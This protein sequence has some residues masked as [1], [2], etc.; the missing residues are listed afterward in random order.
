MRIAL[1]LGGGPISPV[2]AGALAAAGT[3]GHELRLFG[4]EAAIRTELAALGRSENEVIAVYDAPGVLDPAADFARACRESTDVSILNAAHCVVSGEADALVSVC[5][6]RA[7]A[8]AALWHI[9]RLPGVLKPV[10]ACLLPSAGLRTLFL[11]CGA[12]SDCKPWHLLQSALIGSLYAR[13]VLERREPTV[14]ILA[15]DGTSSPPDQIPAGAAEIV[16]EAAGL[17]KYAGIRF[18]GTIEAASIARGIADVVVT[19]GDT[20]SMVWGSLRGLADLYRIMLESSGKKSPFRKFAVALARPVLR[21]TEASTLGIGMGGTAILGVAGTVVLCGKTPEEAAA[22]VN[23]AVKLER[24]EFR[25]RLQ[26]R[27]ADVKTG[28][29]TPGVE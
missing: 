2:L 3:E 13:V 14:R 26:A 19:D 27:L 23:T 18:E 21:E 24:S 20:G 25:K 9:K 8:A 15:S 6:P 22:A 12:S 5:G 17:I 28:M 29:E 1:D 4:P 11:D 10:A 7:A 16:R